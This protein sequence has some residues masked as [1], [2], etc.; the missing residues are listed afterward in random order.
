[1][2]FSTILVSLIAASS[3]LS[4]SIERRDKMEDKIGTPAGN[5]NTN[6]EDGDAGPTTHV[7]SN[8]GNTELD[9][10][11]L[12]TSTDTDD[13]VQDNG[14]VQ[15]TNVNTDNQDQKTSGNSDNQ[16]LASFNINTEC[17]KIIDEYNACLPSGIIQEKFEEKCNIYNSE[18]CVKLLGKKIIENSECKSVDK[19]FQDIVDMSVSMIDFY[20]ARDGDKYC[21]INSLFNNKQKLSIDDPAYNTAIEET[22]KSQKCKETAINGLNFIVSNGD[23]VNTILN[24]YV[25][26]LENKQKRDDSN[27]MNE[28]LKRLN[29]KCPGNPTVKVL[30]E[31]D[32]NGETL[33]ANKTS[34]SARSF[35]IGS[36]FLLS[37]SVLFYYVL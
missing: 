1:M 8:T 15:D 10:Q 29:D 6:G 19:K 7:T 13:K 14:K 36:T 2:K 17:K 33:E 30:G 20:C 24:K 21:P 5:S 35:K 12:E 18:K 9:G 16:A 37:L 32:N 26:K 27:L 25:N 23:S 28:I 4:Y 3:A 22:C 31:F 11:V 34:S